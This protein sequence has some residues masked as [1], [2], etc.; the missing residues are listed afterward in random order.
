[1]ILRKASLEDI[2]LIQEIAEE[3]WRPTYDA[4]LSEQQT[5]YMMPMMYASE[6]LVPQIDLFSVLEVDGV[7]I[8]YCAFE[9]QNDTEGKLHKLYLR[10]SL[11]QKGA[12]TFIIDQ[13][14]LQAR[15][16]GL[17]SIYLN[18]NKQNSAVDF[19]LKK[20]FIK[21]REMVLD[22]GNGY[23]MDDYVMRLML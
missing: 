15:N 8:G 13:I 7:A 16:L 5:Q 6:V 19:Y 23:V 12:G 9:K 11:K 1:M 10:P 17:K 14:S 3:A 21:E 20:G 4:I 22:I 2:P 18:V